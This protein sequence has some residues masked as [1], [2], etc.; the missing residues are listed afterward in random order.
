MGQRAS[1]AARWIHT[2]VPAAPNNNRQREGREGGSRV[3]SRQIHDLECTMV[4]RR[5]EWFEATPPTT[6]EPLPLSI[7]AAFEWCTSAVSHS[8]LPPGAPS[9]HPDA[10]SAVLTPELL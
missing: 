5:T 3:E 8:S 2:Q 10:V 4:R 9:R 6:F 1:R 7:R